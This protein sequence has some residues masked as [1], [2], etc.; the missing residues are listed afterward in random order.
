[1]RP[2]ILTMQA[3]GPYAGTETIDFTQLG[4]RTMFVISGKTGAGKTTIFDGICFAIYGK[5]SGEDRSGVELR[6]Q[7]AKSGTQ[8]EVALEFSLR[9][10]HYYIWR[11][12]QQEKKK[13]RGEGYT[14]VNAKAELYVF[15]DGGRK[16]LLAS[17]VRDTDEKIKELLQLDVNQFRQILMIPQG[18]FRKLLTSD[19]KDKEAILQRLFHTELYKKI[20]DKLKDKAQDLKQDVE[21]I[22]IERTRAL[23]SLAVMDHP[24]LAAA[25]EEETPNDTVVLPMLDELI[26]QMEEFLSQMK[27]R[28]SSKKEARDRAKKEWDEAEA[29][30]QQFTEKEKLQQQKRALDTKKAEIEAIQKE[31]ELA[32][33]A[34]AIEPQEALC[35]R[36]GKEMQAHLQKAALA[37]AAA[38]RAAAALSAAGQA[39]R[40]EQEK[41]PLRLK[42]Q[43]TITTLTNLTGQVETL[44]V[45]KT[46][47]AKLQAQ[48]LGYRTEIN[49]RQEELNRLEQ[50]QIKLKEIQK[51]SGQ[52]GIRVVETERKLDALKERSKTYEKL[53]LARKQSENAA[54][55]LAESERLFNSAFSVWKDAKQTYSF[56]QEKWQQGQAAVLAQSLAEGEPCPVCGSVH[57]PKAA[58][59]HGEIPTEKDLQAAKAELERK[60]RAK[61]EAE[62]D[63]LRKK[64]E[65]G[66]FKRAL[67][68][69]QQEIKL[70]QKDFNPENLQYYQEDCSNEIEKNAVLLRKLRKIAKQLE[71]IEKEIEQLEEKK[72]KYREAIELLQQRERKAEHDYIE[73]N[74][75]YQLAL[76]SLPE[77]IRTKN[78]FEEKLQGLKQQKQR[79]QQSLENARK[80]KEQAMEKVSASQA[81]LKQL[82]A[83]ADS[84]EALLHEEQE[85]FSGMLAE[86]G[87]K[88]VGQ[89]LKAKRDDSAITGLEQTVQAFR[90]DYRSVSD[91]Y[92]EMEK[93]LRDI[94]KPDAARLAYR[95]Q[96]LEQQLSDL[97]GQQTELAVLLRKNIEIKARVHDMNLTIKD[98]EEQYK[99][100]GHLADIARGRNGYRITFE[101]FVLASF[102]EDILG[103]ANLRLRKMTGGRYQ[104]KRKPDRSKGNVQS[105]LELMIFDAYTGQERHVKTLSGGE[106][107]KAALAL[108]LGLADIVQQYAGG[109]SLETMFIDEGF[110]TLDPESLDQAVET[111]MDIQSGGR[112]VGIISHVPELN[113]RMDA[114]L[115]V[116]SS[117]HGSYTAFR[118]LN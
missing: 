6:S 74:T 1:M 110:G 23:H 32:R 4:N 95:V 91:R 40:A 118:F 58:A 100:I 61:Q 37:K 116:I 35:R 62:T 114:R 50:R 19:S 98:K 99:L 45:Q 107:F 79:L 80:E 104:L 21:S 52:A 28:Y 24:E 10:Q 101:R 29:L 44:D 51:Q 68:N 27:N 72:R 96:E 20:E 48:Y 41:E 13:S 113:E 84:A 36:A 73:K 86:Q 105:G 82:Q 76:E 25:L 78:E 93:R 67:E 115:E 11:A 15:D 65:D 69:L 12:P 54:H 31:I 18:E 83:N 85:K 66:A 106:S 34:R 5:A 63:R 77:T 2:L 81:A 89:Y 87:F 14:T 9:N 26:S 3:F 56:L 33:K 103:A 38:D 8:T 42:I 92:L 117:Q 46:E 16:Q 7:F 75:A 88:E 60:E 112:L 111:L 55:K 22:Q 39:Y 47:A 49:A 102:L 70:E 97:S 30:L 94:K 109:V 17:N 57:H 108:A 90:E 64:A 59:M 53:S 43:E 71:Q